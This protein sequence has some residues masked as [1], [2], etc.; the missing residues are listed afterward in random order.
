MRL[1][2]VLTYLLTLGSVNTTF[3]STPH[4]NNRPTSRVLDSEDDKQLAR[5][6]TIAE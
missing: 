2:N 6:E 4:I 3:E 1:I 5:E